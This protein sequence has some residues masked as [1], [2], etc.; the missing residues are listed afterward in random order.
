MSVKKERESFPPIFINFG[1]AVVEMFATLGLY[2]GIDSLSGS[3]TRRISINFLVPIIY[4]KA[5]YK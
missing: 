4:F 2:Y 1:K 3:L 5:I